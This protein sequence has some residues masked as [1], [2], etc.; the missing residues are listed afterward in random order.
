M[1]LPPSRVPKLNLYSTIFNWLHARKFSTNIGTPAFLLLDWAMTFVNNLKFRYSKPEK[2]LNDLVDYYKSLD[3]GQKVAIVT[4]SN[5]GIGYVTA[6]YLY[7]A[8][9]YVILA[10]RNEEKAQEAINNIQQENSQGQIKFIKLDLNSLECVVEFVKNFKA[11][12][13]K[14]DLLINNAAIMMTP[15][16]LTKDNIESQI[17]VNF[18]SHLLLTNDLIPLLNE[19]AKIINLSS[20]AS[21]NFNEIDMNQITN[22]EAYNPSLN[23]SQSKL[24]MLVFSYYL[25]DRLQSDNIKVY[26]VNPG[27]VATDLWKNTPFTALTNALSYTVFKNFEAG[28]FTS[29]RCALLNLE[30]SDDN[31]NKSIY[32]SEENKYA[33]HCAVF[34]NDK[35]E[36]LMRWAIDMIKSRGFEVRNL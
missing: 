15:Y 18:V 32:Y 20:T 13:L 4:G 2:Y 28:A 10:C 16:Q 3:Q 31:K 26:A 1:N 34:D 9:Y 8:G 12:N 14:L 29:L 7:K 24:A 30:D 21:F 22:A 35:V 17:G 11:L 23:Y 25:K 36:E 33:P 5:T 6:K 27:I 19:N